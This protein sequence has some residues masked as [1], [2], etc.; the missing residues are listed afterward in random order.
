MRYCGLLE[1]AD[2]RYVNGTGS[3]KILL[4]LGGVDDECGFLIIDGLKTELILRLR[5]LQKHICVI[6]LQNN[7]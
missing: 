7:Q 1:A 6:D 3:V 4:K 5:D 2:G